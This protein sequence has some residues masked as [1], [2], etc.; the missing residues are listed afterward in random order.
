MKRA[1]KL[2]LA[3]SSTLMALALTACGGGGDGPPPDPLLSG[4]SVPTSA[5]TGSSGATSFVASLAATRT[6]GTEPIEIGG[7][8][9]VLA[10]DD[11]AE[12]AATDIDAGS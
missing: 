11:T 10:T 9:V 2:G 8:E 7:D 3:L 4:T 12:P 5:T 6:E 1:S